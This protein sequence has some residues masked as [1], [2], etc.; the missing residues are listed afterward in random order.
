[1]TQKI[2]QLKEDI[3]PINAPSPVCVIVMRDIWGHRHPRDL[4]SLL[5]HL[6]VAVMC[7]AEGVRSGGIDIKFCWARYA[8]SRGGGAKAYWAAPRSGYR[9]LWGEISPL[10][11]L[12]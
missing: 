3:F 11:R 9:G 7:L 1:M 6:A 4:T 12:I 2:R 10:W 8:S 5:V